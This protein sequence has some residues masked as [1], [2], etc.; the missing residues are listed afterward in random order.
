MMI[1]TAAAQ[2]SNE[3]LRSKLLQS[4]ETESRRSTVATQVRS[5]FSVMSSAK[6]A[7]SLPEVRQVY[8]DGRVQCEACLVELTE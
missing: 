6:N 3:R 8:Y 5:Q 2:V 1:S 7:N 4:L